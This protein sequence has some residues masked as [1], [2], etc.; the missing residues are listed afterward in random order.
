MESQVYLEDLGRREKQAILDQLVVMDRKETKETVEM[1][2][3]ED[4]QDLQ[5]AAR[6][7]HGTVA[8]L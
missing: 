8:E 1:T 2:D 5:Y 7:I 6:S 4:Q 3:Q